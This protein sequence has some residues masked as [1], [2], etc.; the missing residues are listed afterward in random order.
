MKYQ[1][2]LTQNEIQKLINT[3][4]IVFKRES[5]IKQFK[6]IINTFINTGM[7]DSELVNAKPIWLAMKDDNVGLIRIQNN[8]YPKKFIPKYLSAREVPIHPDLYCQLKEHIGSREGGYIF[9]SQNK[10]DFYRYN[11][12]TVINAIN[13]VSKEAFNKTIG[14]HIFRR[15]YAS[16][17]YSQFKDVTE[18]QKLMGHGKPEVTWKYI[19]K[20]PTRGNYGE[21]INMDI[22][23]YNLN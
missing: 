3:C 13:K 1:E 23:K 21:I 6:L 4:E 2:I 18:I 15:T 7:R 8:E 19:Q 17:L 11:K 14:T 5:Q 9:R 16:Y 20:I 12:K 22:F 10:K